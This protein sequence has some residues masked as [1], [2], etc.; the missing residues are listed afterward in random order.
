MPT[1]MKVTA[2]QVGPMSFR[3]RGGTSGQELTM[4]AA[5][6]AG[7]AGDGFRPMELL[8][9][10]L[11]GCT[12]MDVV[13]ILRRM[14]E[15]VTGYELEVVGERR[16]EHPKKYTKIT[17]EHVFR[18][19]GLNPK[20]VERAMRLSADKYCSASA[21]LSAGAEVV[22]TFRIEELT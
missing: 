7:G 6:D 11:A 10:G 18:G 20:N 2:T 1:T 21:N 14:R 3:A 15:D 13:S 8:L 9:V 4:D 16:D 19:R 5:T 22:H 12:G 17:V